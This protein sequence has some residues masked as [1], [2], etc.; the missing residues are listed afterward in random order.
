MR[1]PL[2]G[3]P[4]FPTLRPKERAVI[5]ANATPLK[6]QRWLNALTYNREKG[7]ETIRSFRE[8]IRRGQ[9]HCLEAALAA[10]VILEQYG[11][12]PL[13]MSLESQDKLDHVLFVFQQNGRWGSIARSRDLGLHGRKPVFRSLRDL[14]FSYYEPYV[15]ATGRIL[16]YGLT[17]LRVLGN[18]DW[19]FSPRNRWKIQ[20][21]LREIPHVPINSS[22]LTYQRMFDRYHAFKRAHSD[23]A[24][25][26]F[27]G[28][29]KWLR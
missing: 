4:S 14:T 17:D 10:A 11:Y 13:L 24:P 25:A 15:D 7:G 1:Q 20:D 23:T 12:S 2:S 5:K 19:R 21:H 8:V 26:Y 9:A 3:S 16:A 27:A 29:E 28:K 18:Y 22:D 6:V